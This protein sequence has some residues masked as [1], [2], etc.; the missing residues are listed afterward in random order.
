MT[1]PEDI[2]EF[3]F[4]ICDE[5]GG[6]DTSRQSSWWKK[7]PAFDD[8]IRSD[9]G[10]LVQAASSGTLDAWAERP[11]DRVALVVV[12]DQF[13]RNIYRDTPDA[14]SA[15]ARALGLTLDGI[16]RGHDCAVA[17][18]Q[19]V[20]LYMPLMHAEE[21]V[22]QDRG[23]ALF[24]NIAAE[25]AAPYRATYENNARYAIAHRDII[26]RFGRFPHRNRIL[27]RVSTPEEIAFLETPGSSF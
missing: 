3:W 27:G 20:F 2:I 17:P 6:F 26:A 10:E 1:P 9:F 12:L 25:V 21:L 4:G 22:I 23:C 18:M 5:D 8:R 15:D 16:D 14:F 11:V 19:R 24:A 13:R 7:D